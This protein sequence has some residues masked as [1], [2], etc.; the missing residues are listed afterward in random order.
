MYSTL[1]RPFI[2]AGIVLCV[3]V[4]VLTCAV[5]SRRADA[6]VVDLRPEHRVQDLL[7]LLPVVDLL[8]AQSREAASGTTNSKPLTGTFQ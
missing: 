6:L 4:C 8:L 7:L 2:I 5:E 3:C 1:V